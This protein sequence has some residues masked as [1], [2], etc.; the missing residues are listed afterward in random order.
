[1]M[2]VYYK[3]FPQLIMLNWLLL[4]QWCLTSR[5]KLDNSCITSNYNLNFQN[6]IFELPGIDMKLF[7]LNKIFKIKIPPAPF[8]G[9]A[10]WTT[11]YVKM[12]T[13]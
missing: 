3:L 7:S 12:S 9:L 1:M 10:S 4:P 11:V 13:V 2:S 8:V 5:Q 6:F